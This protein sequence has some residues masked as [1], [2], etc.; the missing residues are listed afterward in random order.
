MENSKIRLGEIYGTGVDMMNGQYILP[1]I[2]IAIIA[3]GI[4][5]NELLKLTFGIGF[6]EI[7]RRV[8]RIS[9]RK[10]VENGKSRTYGRNI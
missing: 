6:A 5:Y 10:A 8:I 1:V 4:N 2:I 9:I 7:V 3:L